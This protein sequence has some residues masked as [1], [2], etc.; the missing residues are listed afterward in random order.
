MSDRPLATGRA[1]HPPVEG[2]SR[3]IRLLAHPTGL[4]GENLFELVESRTHW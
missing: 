1:Y 3:E 2:V 4:S